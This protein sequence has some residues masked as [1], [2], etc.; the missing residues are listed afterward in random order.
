[1]SWRVNRRFQINYG[2]RWE[3]QVNPKP[4]ATNTAV[5]SAIQAVSFP[6]GKFDPSQLQ[7]NLNQWMPRFGFTYTPFKNSTKTVVRGHSGIF[8][9]ASPML[10]YGGTT[11]NFR[12]PPGDLSIAYIPTTGQPTVY[13]IFKTAGFDLNT[14][15]LDNLPILTS[16]QL[17]NAIAQLTG[18]APN[19][20]LQASFTG[21]ANNYENPRAFQA[22]LGVDQEIAHNWIVGGQFNY[23]NTVHLERNR[24]YNLPLPTLRASDGRFIFNRNNRPLPQYGQIT[25]RESS[26]HSMYRGASFNTRYTASRRV[27][28]GIQYTVAQAYSDDDNERSAGGFTYDNPFNMRAEY[29]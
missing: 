24:D 19:P 26:A 5:V 3:G 23:V 28:F 13:Q 10:I 17:T 22:G 8:Y 27:Q 6:A 11:N 20:F 21:T 16:T 14:A 4:V 25:L 9:A 1:D 2:V 7:N 12:I 18:A 29:G 15:K